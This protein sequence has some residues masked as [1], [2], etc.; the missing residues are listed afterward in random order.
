MCLRQRF[1]ISHRFAETQSQTLFC[2]QTSKRLQ[3]RLHG[4]FSDIRTSPGS[5]TDTE[6]ET[7]VFQETETETD[8]GIQETEKNRKPKKKNRK[9]RK[10]G[11]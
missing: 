8:V 2:M 6:T 3:K 5:V 4:T 7:A 9:Y 11:F 1:P 10:V